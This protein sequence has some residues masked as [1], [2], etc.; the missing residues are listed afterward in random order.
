[1]KINYYNLY[2]L[3]VLYTFNWNKEVRVSVYTSQLLISYSYMLNLKGILSFPV[4]VNIVHELQIS[5]TAM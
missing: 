5:I 1:M 3:T 2:H 4:S